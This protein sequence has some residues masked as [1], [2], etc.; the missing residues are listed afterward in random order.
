MI[1]IDMG[2][3]ET[4]SEESFEYPGPVDECKG[5]GGDS[6]DEEYNARMATIAESQQD[7]AQDYFDW[8]KS[9]YRPMEEAQIAANMELI[10]HETAFQGAQ[11]SAGMELLPHQTDYQKGQYALGMAKDK[12]ALSLLPQ[13]TKVAS[14]FYDEALDGVD[15][16][17]RADQAQADVAN[18]FAGT[19]EETNRSLARMGVAPG[20]GRQTT[21][22]TSNAIAKAKAIGGARTSA[23]TQAEQ[24]NFGRLQ[25]AFGGA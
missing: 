10:P 14:V 9:D 1:K 4:V 3:G 25:S 23:R 16:N 22:T 5:G 19:T 15:V 2:T 20:S 12:S 13:Q 6:V 11:I 7:M 21:A 17:A 18:A 24:E 8:Y